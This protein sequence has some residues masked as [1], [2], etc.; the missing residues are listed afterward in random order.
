[1]ADE[2]L[3][4]QAE[5][6][7]NKKVRQCLTYNYNQPPP[8]SVV[9]FVHTATTSSDEEVKK[10]TPSAFQILQSINPFTH[11]PIQL[12]TNHKNGA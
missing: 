9:R 11:S 5:V 10:R 3:G 2:L 4:G 6:F 7:V 8:V 12:F 1:L